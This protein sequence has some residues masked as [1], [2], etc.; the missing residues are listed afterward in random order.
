M[1][2]NRNKVLLYGAAGIIL[3][4]AVLAFIPAR[5]EI[6]ITTGVNMD[7]IPGYG[8]QIIKLSEDTTQ[9]SHLVLN[10]Q[11]IEAQMPSGEWHT[12]TSD[13][14]QWDIHQEVE[15]IIP[16]D[17]SVSGYTKIRLNIAA[18][19]PATLTDGSEIQLGVPSYP[20]I[21]DLTTPSTLG[22][23][24]LQLSQG[25]VSNYMLPNLQVEISTVKL[26]AESTQ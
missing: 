11:S 5:T 20:I 18:D 1:A 7:I 13:A 22:D 24:K 10:I 14:T 17:Q 16:L 26:T 25:T 3:A 19:S 6:H 12:I 2:Y 9:L 8:F 15:K 21:I 23:L 4:L